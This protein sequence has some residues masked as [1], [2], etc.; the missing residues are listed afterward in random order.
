MRWNIGQKPS[1]TALMVPHD[2][3]TGALSR[4]VE[5]VVKRPNICG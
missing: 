3:Q 2:G 1:M 5:K 4:T